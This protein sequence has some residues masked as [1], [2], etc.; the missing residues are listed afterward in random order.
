VKYL[1]NILIKIGIAF[2]ILLGIGK[3]IGISSSSWVE[4]FSP[5]ILAIIIH[6]IYSILKKALKIK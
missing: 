6:F 4:V 5:L 3:T 2:T 1:L